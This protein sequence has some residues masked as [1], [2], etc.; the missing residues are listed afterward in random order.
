[1]LLKLAMA[2]EANR[3]RTE[4]AVAL[5]AE[6]IDSYRADCAAGRRCTELGFAE[7][8]YAMV[9]LGAGR[10][11]EA[12]A[13]LT[14]ALARKRILR[15]PLTSV[16]E[17]LNGLSYV[18][19]Y[20][21][22]LDQAETH[23]REALRLQRSLGNSVRTP[24]LAT[25]Q[26]I[27]EVLLAK[28]AAAEARAQLDTL[29][30]AQRERGT[31]RCA[32]ASTQMLLARAQ[33]LEGEHAG[34]LATARG[35]IAAAATCP[36][37]SRLLDAEIAELVA[38]RA[39]AAA[40]ARDEA[41]GTYQRALRTADRFGRSGPNRQLLLRA[42][43]IRLA[44]ALGRRDG[45]RR[46]ARELIVLLDRFDASPHAPLRLEA[47]LLGGS[48]DRSTW[49]ERLARIAAWPVGRRLQALSAARTD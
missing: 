25:Q 34:A 30:Q 8:D 39:L 6:M 33:L 16:A 3:A 12:Q 48:G 38:G 19:T 37:Y 27:A 46:H 42:E 26:Q 36:P 49:S 17:T 23:A 28:E 32:L 44:A 5:G 7:H 29:L 10:V 22:D 15:L 20:R 40:G 41:A 43:A 14:S 21:G 2:I 24:P 9:L 31:D 18:A 4:R 35:A 1:M 47:E 45:T 11:R 13:L